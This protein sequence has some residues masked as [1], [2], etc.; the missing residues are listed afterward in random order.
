MTFWLPQFTEVLIVPRVH[1]KQCACVDTNLRTEWLL[2]MSKAKTTSLANSSILKILVNALT[3]TSSV[4]ETMYGDSSPFHFHLKCIFNNNARLVSTQ[5]ILYL[6]PITICHGAYLS[7]A[8]F[9]DRIIRVFKALGNESWTWIF[10]IK[11]C[12]VSSIWATIWKYKPYRQ[13]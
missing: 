12:V 6:A 7:S 1:P 3:V 4:K 5:N 11:T 13:T 2:H 9:F 10:L 8:T